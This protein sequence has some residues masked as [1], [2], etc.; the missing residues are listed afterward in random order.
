MTFIET[1]NTLA[2]ILDKHE[3]ETGKRFYSGY[4]NVEH[5]TKHNHAEW[6][7]DNYWLTDCGKIYFIYNYDRGNGI[8]DAVCCGQH[9]GHA[10]VR[11]GSRRMVPAL[12]G[13]P[14]HLQKVRRAPLDVRV[15]QV[16]HGA[17]LGQAGFGIAEHRLEC[18]H[19]TQTH[20]L[21]LESPARALGACRS[22]L[23]GQA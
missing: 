9:C 17:L 14:C 15:S 1:A 2:D 18:A 5:T 10:R 21:P 23:R 4:E 6:G 13:S 20:T 22:M 12:A 7:I 19:V 11:V 3:A 16:R 8:V